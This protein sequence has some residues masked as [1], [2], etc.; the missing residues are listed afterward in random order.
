MR[1]LKLSKLKKLTTYQRLAIGSWKNAKDPSIYSWSDVDY[2]K[3]QELTDWVLKEKGIKLTPT[4]IISQS[5]ALVFA[6]RP[7]LNTILRSGVLYQRDLVSFSYM[8]AVT[9]KDDTKRFNLSNC[10]IHDVTKLGLLE[11]YQKLK[12]KISDT[13]EAK[14]ENIKSQDTLLKKVPTFLMSYFLDLTSFLLYT[15]NI[16]LKG[17]PYDPFGSVAISNLG[18]IGV[19]NAFIPLIPYARVPV[20][21]A[22]GLVK[23]RPFVNENREIVVKDILRFCSTINHRYVDGKSLALMQRML[24]YI[25]K[26]PKRWLLSAPEDIKDEFKKEFYKDLKMHN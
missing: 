17:V 2:E 18:Q 8:V 4:Y 25:F 23:P 5:I 22:I 6:V 7:Q 1:H 13:K 11:L 15:L 21:I 14:S 26:D 20:L 3:A 10:V 9:K 12:E 24:L 16:R 19:D